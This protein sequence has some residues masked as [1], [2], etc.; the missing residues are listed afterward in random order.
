MTKIY[1][2]PDKLESDRLITRKLTENDI[3]PWADF[4]SDKEAVQ[5]F[6]DYGLT[7]NMERAK[8]WIDKQLKRYA[9]DGIGLQAIIDKRTNNFVG[10]CGLLK[11]E[12]DG[13][14]E[15]EVGYHIFKEYWGQGFAPEAAKLFIDHAFQNNLTTSVISIIATGN[16]KSQRVAD[17]NG[18]IREKQTKW[19]DLEVYI[20][21]ITKNKWK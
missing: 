20:Y 21:R 7:S 3:S 17:K 15:M 8:L 9:E 18:L 14:I 11:Q 12:V 1:P 19:S 10:Q 2:Y 6:P 5:F 16:T 13:L 4:F